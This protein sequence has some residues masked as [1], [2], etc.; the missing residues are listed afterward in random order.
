VTVRTAKL[1]VVT[2]L[3]A[4]WVNVCTVPSGQTFLVKDIRW[5]NAGGATD[6]LSIRARTPGG[7]QVQLIYALSVGAS[8]TGFWTGWV[9]LV[10]SDVLEVFASLGTSTFWVS[11]TKLQGV[12]P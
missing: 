4:T 7:L 5:I 2:P 1:G 6:T 8:T 9:A 10:P 3:A 12:A 11:G